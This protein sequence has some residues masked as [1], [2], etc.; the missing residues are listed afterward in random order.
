M[1]VGEEADVPLNAV[2]LKQNC[3][4][5]DGGS[6]ALDCG[7]FARFEITF[8]F[9]G[10]CGGDGS[11]AHFQSKFAVVSMGC[12]DSVPSC[13]VC[14]CWMMQCGDSLSGVVVAVQGCMS[15]SCQRS[16]FESRRHTNQTR[17]THPQSRPST[18]PQTDPDAAWLC[19]STMHST[20]LV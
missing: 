16:L 12:W 15:L 1:G 17:R 18:R 14:E 13:I 6:Y 4:V 20:S 8:G 10:L 19:E 7:I 2:W 9:G 11:G 3:G 5:K